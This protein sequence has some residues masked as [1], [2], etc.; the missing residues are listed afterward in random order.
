MVAASDTPPRPP[1]TMLLPPCTSGPS[2][3]G[4]IRERRTDLVA[5]LVAATV[6][7]TGCPGEH[8]RPGFSERE[9]LREGLA[10]RHAAR[11]PHAGEPA[12]GPLAAPPDSLSED[13]SPP[14]EPEAVRPDCSLPLEAWRAGGWHVNHDV[15]PSARGFLRTHIDSAPG[16]PGELA[17]HW[18]RRDDEGLTRGIDRFT[19]AGDDLLLERVETEGLTTR[20]VPPLPVT[21]RGTREDGV[22]EGTVLLLGEEAHASA[23]YRLT[24]SFTPAAAPPEVATP[25]PVAWV[26]TQA[27]LEVALT[28]PVEVIATTTWGLGSTLLVAAVRHQELRVG[29]AS[30]E[31]NEI[32]RRIFRP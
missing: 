1:D 30:G 13:G 26:R 5:G 23:P 10:Q 11:G 27:R 6:L 17:M 8:H 20:F 3:R 21:S 28:P 16:D 9:L 22:L 31:R 2:R 29:E 19:C 15:P 24:W 18:E 14:E 25:E 32:A 4:T 12:A 7:F